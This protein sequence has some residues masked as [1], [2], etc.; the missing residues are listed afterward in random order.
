MLVRCYLPNSFIFNQG[1][2]PEWQVYG[3]RNSLNEQDSIATMKSNLEY[4]FFYC[5]GSYCL[6]VYSLGV[7]NVIV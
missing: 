7:T 2:V 5:T 3:L 4:V 6:F 1:K